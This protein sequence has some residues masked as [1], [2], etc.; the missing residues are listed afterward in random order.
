MGGRGRCPQTHPDFMDSFSRQC[1]SRTAEPVL[2][3]GEGFLVTFLADSKFRAWGTWEWLDSGHQYGQRM[4]E[5]VEARERVKRMSQPRMEPKS[6]G[7]R[8]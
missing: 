2:V 3:S 1:I 7:E 8:E 4:E 5:E 6:E